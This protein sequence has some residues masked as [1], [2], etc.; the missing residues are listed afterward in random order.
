[1]DNLCILGLDFCRLR[2]VD[3][4][5]KYIVS[6]Y[7]HIDFLINNAAT[8]VR[9]TPDFY[10]DIIEIEKKKLPPN[11]PPKLVIQYEHFTDSFEVAPP[12]M[13]DGSENAKAIE[14]KKNER[15]QRTENII[16]AVLGDLGDFDEHSQ[17]ID[18]R[19]NNSWTATL[20]HIHPVEI[21]ETIM[22]NQFV[23]F[24]FI[25][26][27]IPL[28]SNKKQLHK[29]KQYYNSENNREDIW[30][31]VSDRSE[32]VRR[33]Y[34]IN[35]SAM[36]GRFHFF[37]Q[38]THPHTN[39]A[40]A[41]LN[42]LTRTSALKLAQKHNVF[43]VSVDTGW[44]TDELPLKR[45]IKS[46]IFQR[47]QQNLTETE[48]KKKKDKNDFIFHAPLDEIDGAARVLHPIWNGL[49]GKPYCGVFL[50]DYR[51]IDW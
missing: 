38:G 35:V 19:N 46:K 34:V 42:M 28:L 6:K 1:M 37:K 10:R 49:R 32:S 15:S 22:V 30:K 27:L 51:R 36:E 31:E 24:L 12:L 4:F 50:K 48:K 33:S 18:L 39:M 47:D 29:R 8:T 21:M 44:V 45:R 17:P 20:G 41:A 40:K 23:P 5:I 14:Y 43:M 16:N 3:K 11:I 26:Q 9:R 25:N 13:I 7:K 2:S